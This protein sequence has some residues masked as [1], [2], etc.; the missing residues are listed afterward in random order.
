MERY[1]VNIH[2]LI[3]QAR[4]LPEFRE[5]D[6]SITDLKFA[7]RNCEKYVERDGKLEVVQDVQ[8]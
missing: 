1:F 7:I 6:A 8:N 3:E 5:W 4:L 2:E